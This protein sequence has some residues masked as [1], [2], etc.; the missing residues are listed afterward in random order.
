MGTL[1]P[2][3]WLFFAKFVRKL[4]N[5]P[6]LV[7]PRETISKRKVDPALKHMRQASAFLLAAILTI[8]SCLF[9][10]LASGTESK[11]RAEKLT[12]LHLLQGVGANADGT[13]R[14]DLDKAPTRL[15]GVIML[16]RLL[17]Q[18]GAAL[19]GSLEMPFTDVTGSTAAYVA[20]AYRTGITNGTSATTFTPG[21]LL[22]PRAYLTFL[23]RALG[24]TESGGDF[25]WGGQARKAAS[26]GLIT[27]NAAERID[28]ISLLRQDLVDLSYAALTCPMKDGGGTLAEK[29]LSDGVFTE[30]EGRDAG[31]LGGTGW[32]YD[33]PVPADTS[34]VRYEKK[35]LS[36]SAG[37]LTAH[38]LTVNT[39]NPKVRVKT[40]MVDN[41]LNHTAAFSDIVRDSGGAV[42]VVNG[43][44][45]SSYSTFQAPIGHVMADGQ[46]LYGNSGLTSLGFTADGT[47]KVG[48]PPLFTRLTSGSDQWSVYEINT[49][50][51]EPLASV[52]YTP[53]Y[54]ERVILRNG[55]WAL[56]VE[57]GIISEFYSTVE[58]ASV[59]IPR[60]GYVVYMG[61][62]YVST[63][64][65]RI[66]QIGASISME[67]YLNREDEDGF[68]LDG[69]EQMISGAPRLVRQGQ[70]YTE[71]EA[72]FQEPRFTTQNSPR[73]AAGVNG[74]GKLLL[75]SVPG[76]ATIQQMRE[77]MLSLG[78]VE[79][80]NLDGGA[81][82]GMYWQGS[83][84]ATPS[85][86]LTV[87]LQVF[88]D[89]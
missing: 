63:S 1:Y 6:N 27:Q 68:T 46:F 29:L 72:G 88:V 79:A 30:E 34:T 16:V 5:F 10:A 83:Y 15:Q 2:K 40:A 43:N 45:F 48:R 61:T 73:T 85:R 37:S 44:F 23:L 66:P 12:A 8:S 53:A 11:D 55:G 82:C 18:E 4:S 21:S 3:I 84:L 78:C 47:V 80:V 76:G 7:F 81:S 42:A 69:V 71:L 38:V 74:E 28:E 62:G 17:G 41:T 25:V 26:L 70:L 39:T 86:N 20:Y 50:D 56:S 52:L 59:A 75:V 77:A 9:P 13:I 64:Y 89:P 31:V 57:N 22:S 87:T 36:T 19:S 32:S 35:T 54:G 14:Y 67:Y 58:N 24:Y 49:A 65:F 51:Q 60:N 33:I